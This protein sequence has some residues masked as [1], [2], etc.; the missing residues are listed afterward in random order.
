M[1]A[2]PAD[3]GNVVDLDRIVATQWE[4]RDVIGY[5]LLKEITMRDRLAENRKAIPRG[6][7]TKRGKLYRFP[8]KKEFEGPRTV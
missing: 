5:V 3:S 7:R 8:V 4:Y 6:K 1:D 2:R